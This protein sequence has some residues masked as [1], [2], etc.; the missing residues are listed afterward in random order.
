MSTIPSSATLQVDARGSVFFED[1]GWWRYL[2]F[3]TTFHQTP[4]RPATADE[5]DAFRAAWDKREADAAERKRVENLALS[6]LG[7]TTDDF[8]RFRGVF[9]D[10]K[11]RIVVDTRGG[12]GNRECYCDEWSKLEER[13][14][15]SLG[16][17]HHPECVMVMQSKLRKH[18]AYL[19]DQDDDGDCTYAAFYFRGPATEQP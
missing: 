5:S 17:P 12:G 11:G 13:T 18:P 3:S 19:Y 7:L 8:Y 14:D 4:T 16:E 9:T 2:G 6:V 10:D 1:D 15:Q